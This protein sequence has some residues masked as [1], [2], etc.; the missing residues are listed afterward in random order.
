MDYKN[1]YKTTTKSEL[2]QM[3]QELA[4]LADM[5]GED[6]RLITSLRK[7]IRGQINSEEFQDIINNP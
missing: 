7:Q 4:I 5:W 2:F 6:E 1:F 3:V